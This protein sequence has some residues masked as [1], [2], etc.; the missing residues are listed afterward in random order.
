[1]ASR[2][3]IDCCN[4]GLWLDRYALYEQRG[5]DW[6]LTQQAKRREGA[7]LN[8]QPVK[9]LLDAYKARWQ[10]M[11]DSYRQKELPIKEFK[12]APDWRVVLG[13]GASH[14]LETSMTLHRLYGF[15]IIP[16]SSLKG[17]ARAWNEL[18]P[19]K[20]E[21]GLNAD[22]VFGEQDRAGSVVFFDAIPES[23]PEFKLDVM[24]PHFSDYY[25]G[26]DT[27]PADY[28]S[29]IPIY[30]LTVERTT[31]RFAVAIWNQKAKTPID[32][33]VATL[34][35]ALCNIGLGGK[36]SAGYGYFSE[37]K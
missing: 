19:D 24:N 37:V 10:A 5:N 13:M 27:P 36:T 6:K 2:R 17:L 28:L 9:P 14:V 25:Q 31:F 29:P 12:M 35:G 30:F 34:K 18:R 20:E 11:V 22:E 4:L 1:M 8:F 26:K 33:V 16:G 32:E 23:M 21:H 7:P 3:G 15:P